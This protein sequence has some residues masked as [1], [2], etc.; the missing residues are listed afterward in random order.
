MGENIPA[1]KRSHLWL[2]KVASVLGALVAFFYKFRFTIS[3]KAALLIA[4]LTINL[5][6]EY[7]LKYLNL[8]FCVSARGNLV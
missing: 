3:I 8:C 5:H 6:F 1:T 4:R 2:Y 7:I